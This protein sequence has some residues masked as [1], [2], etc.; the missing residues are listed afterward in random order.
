MGAWAAGLAAGSIVLG[1]V[2]LWAWSRF[3]GGAMD[4]I[5][6]LDE[7]FGPTAWLNIVVAAVVAWLRAH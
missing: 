7:R 3:E 1:F 5:A 2:V 6:Y 4:P